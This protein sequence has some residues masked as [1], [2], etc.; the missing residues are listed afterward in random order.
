MNKEYRSG[1][2]CK[3]DFVFIEVSYI[4]INGRRYCEN[5]SEGY[6]QII[7]TPGI[8]IFQ[9]FIKRCC[10]IF[11]LCI[12][13]RNYPIKTRNQNDANKAEDDS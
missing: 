13:T 4:S 3:S 6:E 10:F 5:F 12:Q 9:N 8:N 11:I 1:W 2:I 7:A